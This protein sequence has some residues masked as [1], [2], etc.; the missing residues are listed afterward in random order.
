MPYAANHQE[1]IEW[2]QHATATATLQREYFLFRQLRGDARGPD[3]LIGSFLA[4]PLYSNAF[5]KGYGTIY[6][7]VYRP[8]RSEIEYVWPGARWQLGFDNFAEGSRTVSLG[9]GAQA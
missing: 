7:A 9:A 3:D 2:E 4:P 5:A 6:T 8:V 1:E